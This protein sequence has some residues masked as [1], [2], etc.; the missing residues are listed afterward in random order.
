MS[1]RR[2]I[3]LVEDHADTAVVVRL[4][5]EHSGY[6]VISA[7]SCGEAC[8]RALEHAPD[9]LICDI[10][11]PDGD[12]VE[13]LRRIREQ[14]QVPAIA[15]SGFGTTD[16]I[17]RSLTAGFAAHLVK[18]FGMQSLLDTVRQAMA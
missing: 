12:G 18:P 4:V 9:L 5:L 7:A 13:L 3:L 1:E 10:G 6:V 11:H 15:V 8:E 2:T 17:R 14:R 16:D